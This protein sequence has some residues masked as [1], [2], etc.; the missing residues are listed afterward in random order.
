MGQAAEASDRCTCKLALA[1][2]TKTMFQRFGHAILD[3]RSAERARQ[4]IHN[5]IHKVTVEMQIL[6]YDQ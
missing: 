5:A 3:A 6:L 2:L 1:L 4:A